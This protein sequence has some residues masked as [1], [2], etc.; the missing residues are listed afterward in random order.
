LP[1][2]GIFMSEFLVVTSTFARQPILAVLLVA[3]LL[4]AFGALFLRLNGIAFGEPV[5]SA[6]PAKA[7]YVP[8]YV[9][10]AIVF[11]AGIYLPPILVV[12]FQHIA[13]LLG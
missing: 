3:G 1:P 8:M 11:A 2:L 9:H 4:V 7:S 6:A 10:F 12:W 13:R 5:G